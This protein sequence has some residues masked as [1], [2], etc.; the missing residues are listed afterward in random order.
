MSPT[1]AIEYAPA[2]GH[3]T[4]AFARWREAAS[5]DGTTRNIEPN[6]SASSQVRMASSIITG[7]SIVPNG[8]MSGSAAGW[9]TWNL[10]APRGSLLRESC[11]VGWCGRYLTGGSPGLVSTPNFS[12]VGGT[13]YR[14]TLDLATGADKQFVNVVVRRGGGGS[15]T[16][17][18][19]SDRVTDFTANRSWT[20]YSVVFKATKTVNVNDPAT[21]DLGA[22]IDLQGIE[23]GTTVM[24]AN[25][26]LVPVLPT[27]ALSRTALLSNPGRDPVQVA[28]PLAGAEAPLCGSF[29][30]L[31]DLA[32]VSWPQLLQGRSTEIIYTRDSTLVDSDGDGIVDSQDRCAASPA[33][34]A[35]DSA[36]CAIGQG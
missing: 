12:I 19:L 35:V 9:S 11:A 2:I 27:E 18:R 14:L 31:T 34:R 16:Y 26:E 6:G 30:R 7:A 33:G 1:A 20:R 10:S 15:N 32:P 23:P 21:Q 28:C 17:E 24:V 4:Y 29:L 22:R 3:N 5:P 36:G 13:W 25:V 8:R